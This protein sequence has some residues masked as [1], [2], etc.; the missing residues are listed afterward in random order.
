MKKSIIFILFGGL[1]IFI[2][3]KF[4]LIRDI[5]VSEKNAID[6]INA[7][8]TIDG[9]EVA[10]TNGYAEFKV[11]SDSASK[12]VFQVFGKPSYGDLNGDGAND[13]VVLAT[14]TGGGSGEF[15]YALVA[16]SEEG[17]FKGLPGV[18]IGDRIAPQSI[19]IKDDVAMI[20]FADRKPGE[21]FVAEPS[22]GVTK[23]LSVEEN[24]VK[25]FNLSSQGE[26]LFAGNLI[27]A[28]E[29]RIFTPCG[30]T[31]H[32]VVGASPAYQELLSAYNTNKSTT[33]PYAS[34]YAVVSGVITSSI[35]EELGKS[36]NFG[37]DI[38]NLM[39]VVPNGSCS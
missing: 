39:K 27:M 17:N 35:P 8:Y 19:L 21:S 33:S 36:Y 34:I 4:S 6:P 16:L 12:L 24:S 2:A 11:A 18:Y 29:A 13:S 31:A 28:H 25:E 23:Y 3:W 37:I 9:Q 14:Q 26:Q 32:W 10:F 30:G 7:T 5:T 15:Y 38:K 20:N 22:V 1:T